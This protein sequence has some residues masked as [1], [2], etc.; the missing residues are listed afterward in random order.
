[1]EPN[2]FNEQMKEK[3]DKLIFVPLRDFFWQ[4][5]KYISSSILIKYFILRQN[6]S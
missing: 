3:F 4:K 5:K 6:T 2:G 1:M